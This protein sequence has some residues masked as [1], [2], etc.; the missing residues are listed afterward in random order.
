MYDH[1]QDNQILSEDTTLYCITEKSTPWSYV[2]LAGN[3]M[4]LNNTMD[5]STGIGTLAITI[6][7]PGYYSCQ[8][9]LSGLNGIFK[10]GIFKFT[11]YT[12]KH[13]IRS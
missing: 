6:D 11:N 9:T 5:D 2:D 13:E 12:G 3:K 8:V 7:N 1:L 10:A 4:G